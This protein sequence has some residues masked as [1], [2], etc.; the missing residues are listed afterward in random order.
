MADGFRVDLGALEDAAAG[1]DVRE[2]AEGNLGRHQPLVA[3]LEAGVPEAKRR[4][5]E[6]RMAAHVPQL[7]AC[8]QAGMLECSTEAARRPQIS[9]A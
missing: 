6:H 8:A 4:V 7:L 1:I 3:P 5:E 9:M 2:A